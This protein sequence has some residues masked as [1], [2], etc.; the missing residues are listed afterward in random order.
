MNETRFRPNLDIDLDVNLD[1]ERIDTARTRALDALVRAWEEHRACL[2]AIDEMGLG[3]GSA[4]RHKVF[5]ILSTHRSDK[6]QALEAFRV[7]LDR[8]I[9][10]HVL[11]HTRLGVLMGSRRRSEFI[12][13][14]AHRTPPASRARIEEL[15]AG[16]AKQR[17]ELLEQTVF[18]LFERIYPRHQVR[19]TTEFPVK[20]ILHEIIDW[21]G[22]GS[23]FESVLTDL[24]CVLAT[25]DS[26]PVPLPGK[27][28]FAR[29]KKAYDFE[30]DFSPVPGEIQTSKVR[31]KWFKNRNVHVWLEREDLRRRMN[32]I[33]ARRLSASN[34]APDR[35]AHETSS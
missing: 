17:V 6:D 31:V 22:P 15:L 13:E 28:L 11:E 1:L 25:L 19:G 26:R 9:W 21:M 34:D 18:D 2:E 27:G 16:L 30:A 3:F 24:S 4:P 23:R 32:E 5:G 20:I 33:V 14:L 7:N 12:R 35:T 10:N 8:D 29:V